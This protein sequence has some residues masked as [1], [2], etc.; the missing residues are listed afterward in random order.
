M[1]RGLQR[2]FLNDPLYRRMG[3]VARRPSGA[4]GDRDEARLQ[5]SKP[6]N[7]IPQLRLH[8]GIPRRKEFERHRTFRSPFGET[9]QVQAAASVLLR[10]VA[11]LRC[12]TQITTL[13]FSAPGGGAKDS[14]VGAESPADLNQFSTSEFAKPR[15]R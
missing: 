7:R 15:R 1:R 8:F 14:I 11:A 3:S 9:L 12:P 4:I 10:C 6:A 5:G 2:C 13:S